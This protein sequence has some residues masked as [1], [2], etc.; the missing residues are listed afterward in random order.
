MA[1]DS[2]VIHKSDKSSLIKDD[3][4]IKE[5][6]RPEGDAKILK[7]YLKKGSVWESCSE[8]RDAGQKSLRSMEE[9]ARVNVNANANTSAD[10]LR[11]SMDLEEDDSKDDKKT[12]IS[13]VTFQTQLK[14]QRTT[15]EF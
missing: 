2:S 14:R 8:P 13:N 15:L 6:V 12:L 10:G 9:A 1:Q 5:H 3:A 4:A 7:Q 11:P